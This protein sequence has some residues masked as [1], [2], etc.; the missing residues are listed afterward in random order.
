M[1]ITQDLPMLSNKNGAFDTYKGPKA[2]K[3]DDDDSLPTPTLEY[4]F[5]LLLFILQARNEPKWQRI[6]RRG[7]IRVSGGLEGDRG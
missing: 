2:R 5:L 6:L 7:K 4:F 3:H 1:D